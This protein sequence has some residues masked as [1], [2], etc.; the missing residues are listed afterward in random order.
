MTS[1]I[2]HLLLAAAMLAAL[3]AAAPAAAPKPVTRDNF[4]RAETDR[5]FGDFLKLSGGVNRMFH[6]R[7]PTPLDQQTVVRMNRDTLYS[8][9]VVD[10]S[11]GGTFTM[12]GSPDGRFVGAH[13]IDN[14]HYD[15]GVAY[16]GGV[17]P[18]PKGVGHIAIAFRVQVY[19]P[20][21]P[22][23]IAKINAWQDQITIGAQSAKPWA[24]GNWDSA[25]LDKLRAD[26]EASCLRFPNFEKAMMPRGKADP[27]QRLCGAA[28]GWGLLPAKT[29][30]YF[31]Y[32]GGH[33]ITEC[34]R[35]TYPVPKNQA[36]WSITVYDD[37]GFIKYENS[38]V[39]SSSVKL[40]PDGTFTVYFGSKEL[41][42]DV[43]NRLDTPE[44]WNYMMRV[45]RPDA[46]VLNGGY[47]LPPATAVRR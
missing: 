3:P 21:D 43:P 31:S 47:K 9:A 29:A 23:E 39:N 45:Y 7:R 5:M 37:T 15:L 2:T 1:K 13:L 44:G 26:L 6:I 11:A 42:G 40:N 14:D 24:S 33:P 36:F 10:T 4:V 35:A 8:V 30:T 20:N 22:K 38:V 17:H 41:C 16:D 32:A 19:D 28:S 27:E 25:S 34:R 18:L 12:P 46:S